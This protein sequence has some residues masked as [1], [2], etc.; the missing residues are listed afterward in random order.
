VKEVGVM[1][2]REASGYSDG[3]LLDSSDSKNR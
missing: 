2:W 3:S 1:E